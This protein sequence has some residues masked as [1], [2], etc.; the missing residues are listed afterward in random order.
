[1]KQQLSFDRCYIP[2]AVWKTVQWNNATQERLQRGFDIHISMAEC[3]TKH[4]CRGDNTGPGENDNQ[5]QCLNCLIFLC[6][7]ILYKIHQQRIEVLLAQGV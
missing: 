5:N 3:E 4:M 6:N 1:M 7:S 2:L